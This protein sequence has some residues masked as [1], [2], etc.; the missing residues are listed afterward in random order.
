MVEN[1]YQSP[2]TTTARKAGKQNIDPQWRGFIQRKKRRQVLL[3]RP[4]G[5]TISCVAN[6]LFPLA[7]FIVFLSVD[8]ARLLYFL[9]LNELSPNIYI[10]NL[11]AICAVAMVTAVGMWDGAKWTWW[12]MTFLLFYCLLDTLSGMALRSI[13]FLQSK[14]LALR[15]V[16]H[17]ARGVGYSSLWILYFFTDNVLAFFQQRRDRKL[18]MGS[19]VFLASGI[20]TVVRIGLEIALRAG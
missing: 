4:L 6:F 20:A 17:F 19:C 13:F 15:D 10:I 9:R 14:R 11:L 8:S 3:D 7:L 5:I 1:P 12:T 16:L 2:K 18:L